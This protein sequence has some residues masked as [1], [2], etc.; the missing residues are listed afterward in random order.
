METLKTIFGGKKLIFNGYVYIKDRHSNEATY[1]R[2]E[3]RGICNARMT[4]FRLDESVKKHPSAHNHPTDL[5]SV[6]AARTIE[7]IKSR[8][9]LTDETTSSVINKCTESTVNSRY[10]E[11]GYIEIP[12]ITKSVKFPKTS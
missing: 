11:Q 2:C 6:E 7:E 12:V 3:K 5:S 9:I 10:N 8:A 4:T 1:W